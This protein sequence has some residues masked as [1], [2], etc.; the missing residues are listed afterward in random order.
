MQFQFIDSI[1]EIDR[2]D[3]NALW[4]SA[5]P[6]TRYEFLHALEA[7]G[8]TDASS[9]WHPH[10][11][12]AYEN[13]QLVFAMPMYLKTHSYGEYVFDWSWADAYSR[14]GLEYYPK[15]L[16][17][18][19]FTPATGPRFAAA[20]NLEIDYQELCQTIFNHA[21]RRGISSFHSLFPDTTSS[22]AFKE[23]CIERN[24]CQFH[25]FNQQYRDFDDFLSYFSS[26]KR[27]NIRKER[28][29]TAAF[30]IEI[31]PA[32]E[33]SIQD[34][35]WF[36]Q[37]YHRTY[38]KRSGRPGYLSQSFFTELAQTLGDQLLLASASL[39]GERI[40]GAVYFR[41]E[42]CLYGRYWGSAM[43]IDGLH[44]ET[45]YYKGIEYAIEK[46]IQRF[47]PGAQ[48]EHKI[49]RGF[50]SVITRSYHWIEHS[51]FRSAINNFCADE[52]QHN[53]AYVADAR[54]Y[55]PFKEGVETIDEKILIK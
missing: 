40:A 12:V 6:F 1:R 19:P 28:Q 47:D 25:W 17:A 45:C 50:Q 27:K 32:S 39:N 15:L 22:E 30:D 5:Y 16:N 35:H 38:L 13:K 26:R 48:G 20:N 49:Q 24:G 18:V 2:E 33:R 10:H 3:W 53:E 43:E 31:L 46:N 9:G 41:D 7:S 37:L 55:L 54:S 51:E 11:L 52:R 36:Y 44:F 29:K 21:N 23:N 4:P 14:S 42:E 34:W 8:S